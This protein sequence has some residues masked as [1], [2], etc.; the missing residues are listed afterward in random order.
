VKVDDIGGRLT[1]ENSNG[2]VKAD[3]VHG[4]A[5]VRTSFGSVRLDQIYGGVD[6][7]NQNGT[8]E[9]AALPVKTSTGACN[10]INLRTSFSPIRLYIDENSK[11]DVT[12]HTSLGRVSSELPVTTTG[13]IGGDSLNAKINGGGCQLQLM[14]NN[15]SIE[16]LKSSSAKR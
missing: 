13:M 11:Y 12:A 6:V 7:E 10:A 2:S 5:S 4:P 15:G 3:S 8:V 9:V 16:I 1:V 14:N